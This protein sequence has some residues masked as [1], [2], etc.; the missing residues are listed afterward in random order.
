MDRAD[1]WVTRHGGAKSKIRLSDQEQQQESD[2]QGGAASYLGCSRTHDDEK[3]STK[4]G[5]RSIYQA[6]I[7]R[8]PYV[9]SYFS[10]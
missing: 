10:F 8:A 5:S 7:C 9:S 3:M 2:H 6:C 1:G 4:L